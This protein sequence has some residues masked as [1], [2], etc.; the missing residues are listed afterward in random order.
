MKI[1]DDGY[2][3]IN[4]QKTDKVAKG[5][6][7]D[8][9]DRGLQGETGAKGADGKYYVPNGKGTFDIYQNGSKIEETAIKYWADGVVTATKSDEELK[10]FGVDGDYTNAVTISLNGTL[11]SLVFVPHLYLDGIEAIQYKWIGDTILKKYEYRY[12]LQNT[13]Y[14]S[15][16]RANQG[17]GIE[18]WKRV[19]NQLDDYLPNRLARIYTYDEDLD[20]PCNVIGRNNKSIE[21][22]S[23]YDATREWVYG[24]VWPVEYHLNPATSKVPFAS[25]KPAFNV[26]EPDVIYYNTRATQ[27]QL[28]ITS[29][30]KYEY[31]GKDVDVYGIQN[32]ILTVGLKIEHPQYL[33]P[34][35][36]DETINPNGNTGAPTDGS[37]ISYPA[38]PGDETY[39]HNEDGSNSSIYPGTVVTANGNRTKNEGNGN[40]ANFDQLY[41]NWYGFSKYIYNK[42]NKDNTIALQVTNEAGEGNIIT[43][44]YALIV[45]TRAQLEAL[46]WNKKPHYAEPNIPGRDYGP[47]NREGDEEGW[48]VDEYTDCAMASTPAFTSMTLLR[49]LSPIPTVPLWSSTS[50]LTVST[51][52]PIWLFTCWLRT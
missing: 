6:K 7:G 47:Q 49:R 21:A 42:D 45:P 27:S 35:P 10:L 23:A 29:P 26:L 36:T 41:A 30:Q 43:S 9:G 34:W 40:G 32:G 16:H 19:W 37:T 3:V 18:K 33:A 48:A 2:W 52:S 5:E 38:Y 20:L 46:V 4:G 28:N 44:D 31:Y 17:Q 51:S 14:R 50:I 39:G 11:S 22:S 13:P 24:P 8:R 12:T 15:H 1:S 25:S